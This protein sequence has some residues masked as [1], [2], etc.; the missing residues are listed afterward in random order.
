MFSKNRNVFQFGQMKCYFVDAFTD[1]IFKGNPAAICV[2][3]KWIPDKLMQLI[4]MEHNLS[5]TAFTTKVGDFYELRWF[6]PNGEIDLCG[7]ATL[8][9]AYTL[10]RFFEPKAEKIVFKTRKSGIFRKTVH[11]TRYQ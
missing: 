7:H 3:D 5:E 2:L 8:A 4:A 1:T 6:T 11:T 10:C 9:T